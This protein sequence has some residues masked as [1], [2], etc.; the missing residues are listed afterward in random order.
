MVMRIAGPHCP[1]DVIIGLAA[2]IR[3]KKAIFG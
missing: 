3:A 1:N 2:S